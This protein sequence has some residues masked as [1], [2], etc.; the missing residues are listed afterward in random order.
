MARLTLS[1]QVN[2]LSSQLAEEQALANNRFLL[3]QTKQTRIEDLEAQIAR[4]GAVQSE[5]TVMNL[6]VEELEK[7]LKQE[8]GS[9]ELYS[10]LHSEQSVELEQIHALLD[11]VDGAPTREYDAE[12]GKKNRSVITR[13]AGA[14]IVVTRGAKA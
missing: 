11:G 5:L 4:L 13:L 9:K 12:Y 2:A 10:R 14:F 8:I 1:E 7:K 6:K 3:S